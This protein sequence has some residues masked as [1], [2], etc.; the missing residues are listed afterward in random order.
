MNSQEI[1]DGFAIARALLDDLEER[2]ERGEEDPERVHVTLA[3]V[4]GAVRSHDR[5]PRT[6]DKNPRGI[7]YTMD[8]A[9]IVAS[10]SQ[11]QGNMS[12]AIRAHFPKADED[13]V[14][15]HAKRIRDRTRE[16]DA[17]G[18]GGVEGND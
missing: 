9:Q 8:E 10:L 16:I 18:L 6:S 11:H 5:P 3:K 7:G 1:K 15:V 4:V 17:T 13:E 14:Q 12:A 2:I